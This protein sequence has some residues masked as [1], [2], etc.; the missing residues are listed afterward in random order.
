MKD[1][2]FAPPPVPLL[3]PVEFRTAVWNALYTRTTAEVAEMCGVSAASIRRW[4]DGTNCPLPA[5][6]SMIVH[7]L[8]E[9]K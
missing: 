8:E 5:V 6:R 2:Q 9:L 7:K 1:P 4:I 3:T